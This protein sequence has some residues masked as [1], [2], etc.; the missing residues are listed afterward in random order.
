VAGSSSDPVVATGGMSRSTT[1]SQTLA[2]VTGRCVLVRE[3]D[4]VSGLAG[5]SL[6]A[7]IS[8]ESLSRDLEVTRYA[9]DA[10]RSPDFERRVETYCRLYSASQAR[11][12]EAR[13]Q[14]MR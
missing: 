11:S 6:V 10:S 14:E 13:S 9:P 7:G 3:L 4:R 5:A 8:V 2:D 12:P 1:W